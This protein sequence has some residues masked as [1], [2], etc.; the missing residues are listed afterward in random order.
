MTFYYWTYYRSELWVGFLYCLCCNNKKNTEVNSQ[1]M[2]HLYEKKKKKNKTPKI[3]KTDIP[4]LLLL[5]LLLQRNISKIKTKII[6]RKQPITIPA[7]SPPSRHVPEM[8]KNGIKWEVLIK[9]MGLEF[10]QMRGERTSQK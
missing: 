1:H 6:S 5:L 3:G 9:I 2:P 8:E 10:R 7:T 4:L